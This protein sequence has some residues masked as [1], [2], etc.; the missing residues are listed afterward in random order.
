[1]SKNSRDK[2]L[3]REPFLRVAEIHIWLE[4]L[5]NRFQWSSLPSPERPK[6]LFLY[7]FLRS[8]ILASGRNRKCRYDTDKYS[9]AAVVHNAFWTVHKQQHSHTQE[10]IMAVVWLRLLQFFKPAGLTTRQFFSLSLVRFGCWSE[11]FELSE[12]SEL[13]S[14]LVRGKRHVEVSPDALSRGGRCLCITIGPLVPQMLHAIE[15][16]QPQS[17]AIWKITALLWES[18]KKSLGV[19]RWRWVQLLL[20]AHSWKRPF[21]TAFSPETP[22][23]SRACYHINLV[24]SCGSRWKSHLEGHSQ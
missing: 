6:T 17:R 5:E 8:I 7:I 18:L 16:D 9:D 3:T 1:M 22:P 21:L 12:L 19:G 11:I 23:F 24:R 10:L 14:V 15:C 20:P 13:S 4:S 2:Q